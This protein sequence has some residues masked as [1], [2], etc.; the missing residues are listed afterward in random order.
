MTSPT[1]G[2]PDTAPPPDQAESLLGVAQSLGGKQ[3]RLAAADDRE[4]LMLAQRL[5]LPEAVARIL[6][7]RG[8]SAEETEDFLE[9]T[10]KGLLPDPSDLK[11]MDAAVERLK[12]AVETGEKIAV[13]ADYDVD[14]ATSSSLLHRFLSA[15]GAPPRIYVPDR[16]KEGYGPNAEAMVKLKREGASVVVTV[17]C[18]AVAFEPLDAAAKAGLDV[19]VCDHHAGEA[20]LPN[21][22]AVV[23][24]N[25][26]DEAGRHGELAA[27]GVAFLLVVGLNRALRQAGWYANRPEPDP[28]D[29]LDLVALGTVC[30]VV[31]LKGVNRALVA[32]G[33][34]VMARRG[35]AGLR[36]LGDV[37]RLDEAPTAFHAGFVL[38]PRINAGGRVGESDLGSRLLTSDDDAAAR[39]L[40]ERLDELNAERRGLEAA[41]FEG[42]LDAVDA[43]PPGA[44]AVVAGAGWHPGVVGIV[45]SRLVERLNRP[46]CVIALNG[47]TGTGSGRSV[48]GV[49]LGA[50]IIAARQAGLLIKGGGHPMA[51]GFSVETSKLDAFREFIEARVGEDVAA[52]AWTPTL[53]LDGAVG[54]GA[55]TR[56]LITTLA[57]LAPFGAGNPEPRFALP[58]VRVG[59]ADRVGENH[60]RCRLTDESGTSLKGIS[61]RSA[62]TPLGQALLKSDGAAFHVAG[63]LKLNAW[64][65]R[66]TPEVHIDDA[67]PLW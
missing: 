29:W 55:V 25:R 42:A 7:A 5:D 32:Q 49:D 38:G 37:A 10:L 46:A 66:E 40:A 44:A 62:D 56:E 67:A 41:V 59:Y 45:A 64:Q 8:V 2:M 36:A 47:E 30:D 48:S 21:A 53:K 1:A 24:P 9:P 63:R 11:D 65:G 15:V 34:K 6:A 27:V 26:F 39:P 57:R 20:R 58:R 51:A 14:G 18:G 61:F 17:D 28:R 50:A 43:S 23:N 33:L 19:I 4:A 22:V 12:R 35:N 54:L 16:M 13:F 60:V 3:W 31:P 52:S